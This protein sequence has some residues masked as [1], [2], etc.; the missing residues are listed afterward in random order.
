MSEKPGP[1][2]DDLEARLRAARRRQKGGAGRGNGKGLTRFTGLGLA[3]RIG[4]EL[5]SGLAIGVGIGWLLDRWLGT[6]PWL[7][8]VFFFLGSGAGIL[9]VYRTVSGLGH[10]VG[11]GA[12]EEEEEEGEPGPDEPARPHDKE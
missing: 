4:V 10:A 6:G 1:A 9:N 3:F 2:L 5:V 8:V 11:Y 7:M 12:G